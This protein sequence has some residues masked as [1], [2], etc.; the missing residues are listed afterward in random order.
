MTEITLLHPGDRFPAITVALPGQGTCLPA[1]LSQ[2]S[3]S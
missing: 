2:V 1:A 3:T